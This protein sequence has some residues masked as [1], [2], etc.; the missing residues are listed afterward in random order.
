M[1]CGKSA[2][3]AR[4]SIQDRDMNANRQLAALASIMTISATL[5]AASSLALHRAIVRGMRGVT[6]GPSAALSAA[7]FVRTISR[8][9]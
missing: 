9:T 7:I 3:F 1:S 4:R 5:R 8:A 6:R 2:A